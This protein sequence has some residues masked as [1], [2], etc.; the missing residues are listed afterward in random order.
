VAEFSVTLQNPYLFDLEIDSLALSTS[1]L[2]FEPRPIR[3]T[4]PPGSF[5]TVRIGGVAL[6]AGTLSVRG[7]RVT[8]PCALERE[9]LLPVW[10]DEDEAARSKRESVEAT[11]ERVKRIGLE[12]RRRAGD[13]QVDETARPL[14]FLQ[15]AVVPAQPSLRIVATSLTHGA[16]MLYDGEVTT[17]EITLENVGE[18]PADWLDLSFAD[19]HT[20]AA[21]ARLREGEMTAS[22]A[23]EL[24][25]LLQHRPVF[26]W[27]APDLPMRIEAGARATLTVECFGKVGWCVLSD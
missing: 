20:S 6:E 18:R 19:S 8:L 2:R 15:C 24:E 26:V 4:V 7:V 21:R 5:H 16:L 23:F 22:E 27:L 14:R 11:R 17:F 1:G 10:T 25:H 9:F 3:A 13:E 12:A